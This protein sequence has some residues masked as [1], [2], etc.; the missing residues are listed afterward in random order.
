MR[1]LLAAIIG[2]TTTS[3]HKPR[4]ALRCRRPCMLPALEGAKPWSEKP[5]LNDPSR[6]HIAIMTDN[7]GGHRPGIWMKAVERINWMRPEFV[8]SVGDLIEGYSTNRDEIE[9]QWKEFL[10]FIDKMEMKFFFV[11]GNHDVS[12][13]TMHKIWREHFGAE[14]YSFDYKGVHFVCMSSEDQRRPDRPRAARLARK[15]SGQERRRAL[16]AVVHAQAAVDPVR[17]RGDRRQSGSDQLEERRKAAGRSPVH[18]LCRPRAP[19]R[20]V[21]AQRPQVLP[22]GDHRRRLAD[23]AAFPTASSIT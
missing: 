12:N 16:D 8:V 11:A 13:P 4:Q 19:L 10:G 14:W 6:F 1:I 3:T 17:S 2:T 22:P 5:I 21:R 7:T 23:C 15:G 9:A 20:A 18:R